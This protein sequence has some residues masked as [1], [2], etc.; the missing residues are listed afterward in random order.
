MLNINSPTVQSML[1]NTPQGFGNIPVYSGNAPTI[2]TETIAVPSQE[3]Q[4]INGTQQ[5]QTPFPSPK[6]MLMNGG[7]NTIYNPTSFVPQ[8]TM[9]PQQQYGYNNR[10]VGGYN[11]NISSAFNGYYNPYIGYGTYG[12]YGYQQPPQQ[13]VPMDQD[14][15]DRMEA[16]QL[17]G[18]SYDQ[19]L[20]EESNLYKTISRIVSKNL[21]RTEEEAK[22]CENAFE[23]YNKYPQQE[24]PKRKEMK[25]MK[26]SVYVNGEEVVAANSPEKIAVR[27]DYNRNAQYV[28][29]MKSV[30]AMRLAAAANRM[31]QMYEQAPERMFDKMDLLDFFNKGAGVLMADLLNRKL[32]IQNTTMAAHSYDKANF[33]K[34]LLENNG[35][36]SKEQIGAVERF[37]GRYGIMPDGRPVSPGIDPSIATSFSY[38]PKTGQ[39][40]VTAP[41]FISDRIERARSAFIRSIDNSQ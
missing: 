41:N 7:Q 20:H 40:S 15:M 4:N 32:Y 34:R 17:N 27:H 30:Q 5:F 13:Y 18:V 31:N 28:E 14:T 12:G 36:R 10:Y 38:D 1:R 33:R 26:V 9:Y 8:G 16:A 2:T 29:Q 21:N 35:L 25:F 39:Y 19:Q 37:T 23:I 22:E 3:Q 11:P 24:A 6:E